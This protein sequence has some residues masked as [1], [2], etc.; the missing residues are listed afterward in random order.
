[1]RPNLLTAGLIV[2]FMVAASTPA[3]AQRYSAPGGYIFLGGLTGFELFPED[4]GGQF[5]NSLG[6]DIRFGSRLM[7]YLALEVEGNFISGFDVDVPV[8]GGTAQ[9]V[10]EGG[11]VTVNA[12]AILPLGRLEPYAVVGIGG[13]WSKLVTQR[14]TGSVCSPGYYG[15]WCTGTR[16]KLGEAGSFVSKFGAGVDFW[17]SEAWGLTVDAVYVLPTGDLKDQTYVKLGWGARFKF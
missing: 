14:Y 2:L 16:T 11:N 9:L 6:F 13:M 15:W 10:L 7:D 1:M 17:L 8:E 5:E 12:R 3:M 4:K